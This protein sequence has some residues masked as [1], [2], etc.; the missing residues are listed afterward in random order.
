VKI[1]Y[2]WGCV[3]EIPGIRGDPEIFYGGHACKQQYDLE[4]K[5]LHT[6]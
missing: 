5:T 2:I 3:P 1:K 6:M 4:K